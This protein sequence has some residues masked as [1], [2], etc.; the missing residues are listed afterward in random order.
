MSPNGPVDSVP[1]TSGS[2]CCIG[3]LLKTTVVTDGYGRAVGLDRGVT[4][5]VRETRRVHA[6]GCKLIFIGI[7][8]DAGAASHMAIDFSKNGGVRALCLN[9]PSAITC[10]GNDLGFENLFAKQLEFHGRPGDMAIL[11]GGSGTAPVLL[12]GAREASQL[13]IELVTITT[14][15]ADN[16]LRGL[17]N[18]NFHIAIDSGSLAAA[19]QLALCHGFVDFLCG[20]RA[21]RLP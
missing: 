8:A 19:S 21:P 16:P 3:T 7:G 12:N 11:I 14:A 6:A 17:G 13:G 5:V 4:W 15:P 1:I 10:L 2:I 18:L 20:W 9:D